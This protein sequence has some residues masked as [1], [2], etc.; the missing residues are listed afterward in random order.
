MFLIKQVIYINVV[1]KTWGKVLSLLWFYELRNKTFIM[2]IWS[3]MP[4][5]SE[6]NNYTSKINVFPVW[7]TI[8]F[9]P[10]VQKA[11]YAI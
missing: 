8:F 10:G 11:I 5:Q 7:H 9:L 3:L 4:E 6:G 1:K 2:Q